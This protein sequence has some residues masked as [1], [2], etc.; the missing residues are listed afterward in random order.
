MMENWRGNILSLSPHRVEQDVSDLFGLI[1]SRTSS[2]DRVIMYPTQE[3]SGQHVRL[4]FMLC[5]E[6][7]ENKIIN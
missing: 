5:W 6:F 4:S 1:M 2:Y 7:Y 3:K